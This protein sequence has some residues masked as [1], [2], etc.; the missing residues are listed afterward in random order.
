VT[1]RVVVTLVLACLSSGAAVAS[2][3]T[4]FDGVDQSAV[5]GVTGLRIITVRDK[6]LKTC[7]LVFLSDPGGPANRRTAGPPDVDQARAARDGRLAELLRGYDQD[8]SAIPGTIIP[9]PLKY[10]WLADTAQLEFALYVLQQQFARQDRE[11][12]LSRSNRRQAAGALRTSPSPDS[13]RRRAAARRATRIAPTR[14]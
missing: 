6:V 4:R 13:P 5:A 10:D 11:S 2:A 9:N 1:S 8:R 14:R 7:Y 3:Q 12:R